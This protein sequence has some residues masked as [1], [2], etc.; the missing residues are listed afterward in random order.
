MKL[1]DL[2]DARRAVVQHST[3]L[4]AKSGNAYLMLYGGLLL[5]LSFA[6]LEILAMAIYSLRHQVYDDNGTEVE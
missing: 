4:C 1:P 2:I 3:E 5:P 6:Y